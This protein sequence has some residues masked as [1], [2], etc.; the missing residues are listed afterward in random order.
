MVGRNES[1]PAVWWVWAGCVALTAA[2][3][4]FVVAHS[5]VP[6]PVTFASRT[7][8]TV[9]A[10]L[11]LLLPTLGALIV[12]R[13][14]RHRIGWLLCGIGSTIAV[15]I[16]AD[17]WALH[18][19]LVDPGSLPGGA[20]AAWVAN[21]VWAVGWGATAL[22]FLLFPDGRLP[23]RR[24]AWLAAYGVAAT[25]W[26]VA[27]LA[28]TPG[29]LAKYPWLDNP[30]R[31][32]PSALDLLA[33]RASGTGG[34]VAET[35][36]TVPLVLFGVLALAALLQRLRR[37]RG[38]ARQ[39]LATLA[40]A[41]AVVVGLI[42]VWTVLV[43]LGVHQQRVEEL[44]LV[45]QAAV[46]VAAGVVVLRQR[47]YDVRLLISRTLAYT[48]TTGVLAA[49]YV[50]AV[51]MLGRLLDPVAGSSQLAV[52]ASTLAVASLVRPA[53]A[54]VQRAVDSRFARHRYDAVL[55]VEAYRRG[56]RDELDLD[57]VLDGLRATVATTLEPRATTV[58]LRP[59]RGSRTDQPRG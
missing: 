56:L 29:P 1:G 57:A 20:L 38:V 17:G 15:W 39:Q 42:A 5:E 40:V 8:S 46:P 7:A 3:V 47:L 27:V 49:A 32:P 50:L 48:V 30:V 24:H 31:L 59:G 11:Y 33:L 58:W 36:A 45:A 6:T 10:L 9:Q 54:R 26:A 16:A 52:A 2:G 25:A 14:P 35:L 12:S 55:A 21:A 44:S 28:L 53:H 37:A 51:V 22:L 23:S 34:R 19:L 4:A 43:P 18:A 13:H 41:A